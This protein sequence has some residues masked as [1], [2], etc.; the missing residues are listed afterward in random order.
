MGT[1]APEKVRRSS[2]HWCR[3]R[4][5][6]A[7]PAL[8][9]LGLA[10]SSCGRS[11]SAARDNPIPPQSTAH[12]SLESMTVIEC[13][14]LAESGR[15]EEA[16]SKCEAAAKKYS[17]NPMPKFYQAL[18]LQQLKRN[19]DEALSLYAQ[20]LA[21]GYDEF[22]VRYHRGRLYST[23]QQ[24]ENA[25]KDWEYASHIAPSDDL[26]RQAKQLLEGAEVKRCQEL[27]D[28]G[29]FEEGLKRSEAAVREY[30]KNATAKY[31]QAYCLQRANRRLDEAIT[32]YQQALARGFSEF[33]VRYNRGM[34]YNA[35]GQKTKAKED[36]QRALAIAPNREMGETIK[37]LLAPLG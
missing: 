27:V 6:A 32:L 14:E 2:G 8:V 19:P 30:P 3:L 16:L 37:K 20:A 33:W 35:M 4:A 24:T 1:T 29:K 10:L 26:T 12:M 21:L 13:Q 7:V 36:L 18:S 17:R 34:L 28:S 23:L 31:Y 25:C 15:Y 22:W 5:L 9:L 11:P